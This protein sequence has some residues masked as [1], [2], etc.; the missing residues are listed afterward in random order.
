MGDKTRWGFKTGISGGSH[1]LAIF[2]N[3]FFFTTKHFDELIRCFMPRRA[4]PLPCPTVIKMNI[5]IK[6]FLW[7]RN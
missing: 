4:L 2:W 3:G 6:E 5:Q 1:C 7:I